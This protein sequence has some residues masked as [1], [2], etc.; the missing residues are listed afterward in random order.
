M[1]PWKFLWFLPFFFV[2]GVCSAQ[3]QSFFGDRTVEITPFGGSRFGGNINLDTTFSGGPSGPF[4]QLNIR[5]TWDYGAWLDVG[6]FSHLQAE[7]MWDHQPTVLTGVDFT[8]GTAARIGEANLDFYQWGVEVPIFPAHA[9]F[10]PY[11]AGGL[12]FTH[13]TAHSG[14]ED[15][16]P[17]A[18]RFSFNLGGGV[19]YYFVK[20][21][22]LRLDVRYSPTRTTDSVAT[23]C[24]PFFGCYPAQVS[25]FAQ[26]GE[27]NLGIIFRF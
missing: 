14:A 18:N 19:K 24:D 20:H 25:N 10:Q 9:R 13:F 3:A 2:I 8:S 16:L 6:I 17:F 23:Y 11:I 22:G 26:Q 27:A 5:S 12:G 7:F 4:D 21:V 1:A 15:F